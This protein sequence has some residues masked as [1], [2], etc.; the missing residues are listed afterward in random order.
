MKQ[1]RKT[2]TRFLMVALMV[3]ILIGGVIYRF[4]GGA[5]ETEERRQPLSV[6]T[7]TARFIEKPSV[8]PLTGNVEGLTSSIISSRFSGQVT[9]I[10]VEDGQAVAKG[11]PLFVMDTVELSNAVRVAQNSVNQMAAKYANDQDEYERSL[12]LFENGAYSRQQ[13][14]SARTKMLSSQADFDSAQANLNSAEKQLSEATVVSPV[15]GVVANKNL[16]QGQNVSAG[17]QVMTVEELTDV[18]VVIQVEQRD[19]AYLKMGDAVTVKADAYPNQDFPGIVDVISPVAGRE[20]RMFRVKVKVNNRGQLLRPGMFVQVQ[21]TF[22]EPKTVLAISKKA[23]FGQ[24]GLQYVFAVEDGHARKVRVE[25][26][27]LIGDYVEIRPA[28]TEVGGISEG[29]AIVTDNLDKIKDG[30]WLDVKEVS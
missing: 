28:D 8:M 1:K 10:F 4:I 24:K 30:D 26:G 21:I 18:H 25:A 15:S 14:D 16:T 20:S 3:V 6:S 9:D 22:G 11:Q 7:E 29:M 27:D 2:R 12:V 13:L 5:E 23:L 19:M 17:S